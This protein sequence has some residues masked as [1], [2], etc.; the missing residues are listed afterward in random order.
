MPG[1][2]SLRR[3]QYY[4]HQRNHFWA[5]LFALFGQA[6]PDAYNERIAFLLDKK[7]A[8]WDVLASCERIGSADSNIRQPMPNRIVDLLE[9]HPQIT[10]V[11]LNGKGA[12]SHFNK[13]ILPHMTHSVHIETLPSTSPAYAI[14][15]ERKLEEWK[16]L[17]AVLS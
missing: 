3:Q 17:L 10:G 12:A 11:F 9:A 7:I 2:E 8:L 1:L 6:I 5:I 14:S 15:F 13:L 16:K 4:A